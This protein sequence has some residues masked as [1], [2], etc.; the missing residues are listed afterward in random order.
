MVRILVYYNIIIVSN[1]C[2]DRKPIENKNDFAISGNEKITLVDDDRRCVGQIKEYIYRVIL[3]QQ[4]TLI[5]SAVIMNIF[6]NIFD[7]NYID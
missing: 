6:F 2:G 4:E 5:F 3:F 1:A 7:K